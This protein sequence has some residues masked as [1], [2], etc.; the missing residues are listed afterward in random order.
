M[1]GTFVSIEDIYKNV[2]KSL[3]IEGVEVERKYPGGYD[4][5][6]LFLVHVPS[7]ARVVIAGLHLD[8]PDYIPLTLLDWRKI[9]DMGVCELVETFPK[10]CGSGRAISLWCLKNKV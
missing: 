4:R 5:C 3:G 1:C 2:A 6:A 8:D 7:G 9:M 10:Q